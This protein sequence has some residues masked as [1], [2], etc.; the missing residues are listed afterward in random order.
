MIKHANTFFPNDAVRVD[1]ASG[2]KTATTKLATVLDI[3]EGLVTVRY[4][5]GTTEKVPLDRIH[6]A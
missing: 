3:E 5:D 1:P 4:G 2:E 6:R